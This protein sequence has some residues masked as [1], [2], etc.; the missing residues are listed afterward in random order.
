MVLYGHEGS[1]VAILRICLNRHG[2]CIQSQK[3][4]KWNVV[5]VR[6]IPREFIDPGSH[7][8]LYKIFSSRG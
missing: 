2:S 6:D 3:P 5:N 8:F 7:H 1:R 4:E